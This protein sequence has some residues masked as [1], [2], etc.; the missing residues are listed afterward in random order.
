MYLPHY[1]TFSFAIAKTPSHRTSWYSCKEYAGRSLGHRKPKH[2]VTITVWSGYTTERPNASTIN[3]RAQELEAYL[4]ARCAE[5]KS[6]DKFHVFT[7]KDYP[8]CLHIRV[9]AVWCDNR[10]TAHLF[11]TYVR[12]FL[13]DRILDGTHLYNARDLLVYGKEIGLEEFNK[14][15]QSLPNPQRILGIVQATD[16]WKSIQHATN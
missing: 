7:I 10:I 1:S 12:S 3:D 11:F 14:T 6:K 9:P 4:N 5:F 2:Y 13:I 8:G 16:R 15:L